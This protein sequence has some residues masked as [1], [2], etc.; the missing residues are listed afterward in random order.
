MRPTTTGR[1]FRCIEHPAYP[2]SR[3]N[4]E[5]TLLQ[6]S[7]AIGEYEDSLENPGGS[8]LWVGDNFHLDREEVAEL[9]GYLNH[10]LI[11]L[12]LPDHNLFGNGPGGDK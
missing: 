11:N 8:Y 7:S 4:P 2:P 1:G 6:E 3:A 10:W 5:K 12:R 9:I